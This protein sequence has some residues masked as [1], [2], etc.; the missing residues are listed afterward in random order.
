MNKNREEEQEQ[1]DTADW[2]E[3]LASYAAENH[4]RIKKIK[5]GK[6]VSVQDEPRSPNP[7]RNENGVLAPTIVEDEVYDYLVTDKEGDTL[8]T[9]QSTRNIRSFFSKKRPDKPT[10]L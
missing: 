9:I 1:K 5:L 3:D 6:L 2:A 10:T 7:W 8:L 4:A